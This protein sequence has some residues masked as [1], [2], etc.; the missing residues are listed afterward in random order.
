MGNDPVNR[1]D[2]L[3]LEG[4][5]VPIGEFPGAGAALDSAG[6]QIAAGDRMG[7]E[8]ANR[9]R[10]PGLLR[11]GVEFCRR[12]SRS[13]ATWFRSAGFGYTPRPPSPFNTLLSEEGAEA[14]GAIIELERS[15]LRERNQLIANPDCPIAWDNYVRRTS[16]RN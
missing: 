2:L 3:G 5:S 10:A 6:S 13:L 8:L 14:A 1:I 9:H 11:R 4:L 12:N 15:G 16:E 7:A